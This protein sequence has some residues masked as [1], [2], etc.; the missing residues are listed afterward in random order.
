MIYNNS[1]LIRIF[2]Y[3]PK[4]QNHSISYINNIIRVKIYL[5][6]PEISIYVE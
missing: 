5:T 3:L 6:V 1:P 4:S 2:Q